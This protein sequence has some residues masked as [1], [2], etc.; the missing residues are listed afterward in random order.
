M[1]K[2]DTVIRVRALLRSDVAQAGVKPARQAHP[3]PSS[4]RRHIHHAATLHLLTPPTR[5]ATKPVLA[6]EPQRSTG[7]RRTEG[8][9]SFRLHLQLTRCYCLLANIWT[10][11]PSKLCTHSAAQGRHSSP[12]SDVKRARRPRSV[13][14]RWH[15]SCGCCA[16]SV[17]C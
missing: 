15:A 1:D 4:V 6:Q 7:G 2:L 5:G 14:L 16:V 8:P 17:T 10:T 3:P 9:S 11:T 13:Q 12:C